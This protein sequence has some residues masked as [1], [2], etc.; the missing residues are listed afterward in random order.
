MAKREQSGTAVVTGESTVVRV[1][2]KVVLL[3]VRTMGE[4]LDVFESLRPFGDAARLSQ[5]GAG[6]VGAFLFEYNGVIGEH[7]FSGADLATLLAELFLPF[8]IPQSFDHAYGASY[9]HVRKVDS[10]GGAADHRFF[11]CIELRAEYRDVVLAWLRRRKESEE[12]EEWI[13]FTLD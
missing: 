12:K 9:V 1:D 13:F 6:A 8:A 5:P 11:F 10:G 7:A 4:A 3:P 2:M